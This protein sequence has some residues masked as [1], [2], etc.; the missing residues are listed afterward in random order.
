VLA[1]LLLAAVGRGGGGYTLEAV[2]AAT[3]VSAQRQRH[4]KDDLLPAPLHGTGAVPRRAAPLLA[5]SRAAAAAAA[6]AIGGGC[7]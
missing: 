4:V 7:A 5:A 3:R 1:A 2:R 6:A